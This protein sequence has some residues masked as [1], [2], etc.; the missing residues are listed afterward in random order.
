[1]RGALV[2]ELT[3]REGETP[4]EALERHVVADQFRAAAWLAGLREHRR[5]FLR[6]G[7]VAFRVDAG[8]DAPAWFRVAVEEFRRRQRWSVVVTTQRGI[9]TYVVR[10]LEVGRWRRGSTASTLIL[11]GLPM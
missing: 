5:K 6:S 2:R 7:K 4:S 3:T 10:Y 1:M 11:T 8:V 9:R